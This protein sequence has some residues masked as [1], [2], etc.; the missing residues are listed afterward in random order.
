MNNSHPPGPVASGT[1]RRKKS[2]DSQP[3]FTH[4]VVC[5]YESRVDFDICPRCKAK[6]MS[7]LVLTRA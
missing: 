7:V 5:N 4:C 1:G 2:G 3:A 6:R